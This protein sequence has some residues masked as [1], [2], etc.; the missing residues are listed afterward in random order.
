[1]VVPETWR[2]PTYYANSSHRTGDSFMH[3]DEEEE[4]KVSCS[5]KYLALDLCAS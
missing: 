4:E 1:M 2:S 3:Y 5:V